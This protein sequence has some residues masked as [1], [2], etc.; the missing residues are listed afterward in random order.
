MDR[1][2]Q[3][4]NSK[5]RNDLKK[6][7]TPQEIVF[8]RFL[9]SNGVKFIFQK[10]FLQPFHRI[11]DFYIKKFRL[12][13]EIDGGYHKEC[14][15]KDRIKDDIW[16]KRRFRTLR[17]LNEDVDNGNYVRLFQEC[18]SSFYFKDKR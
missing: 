9:E 17:I 7:A 13:V 5:Y 15:L 10:G 2:K 14:A 6:K 18:V 1:E 16:A 3:R 8:K 12:I 4:R 11:A